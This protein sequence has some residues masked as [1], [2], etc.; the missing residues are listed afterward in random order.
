[1]HK[2]LP[3]LPGH[4]FWMLTIVLVLAKPRSGQPGP[5]QQEPR[6]WC[7][8]TNC[9]LMTLA[10][11]GRARSYDSTGP[12]RHG[13]LSKLLIRYRYGLS[14]PFH[15]RLILMMKANPFGLVSAPEFSNSLVNTLWTRREKMIHSTNIYQTSFINQALPLIP[16]IK[17][18]QRHQCA[19]CMW[20]FQLWRRQKANE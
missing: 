12:N 4:I 18:R 19:L 15:Y 3:T 8:L 2:A 17:Q 10:L 11:E 16:G 5:C 14:R 13:S 6:P 20:S 9:G 1:M 7:H